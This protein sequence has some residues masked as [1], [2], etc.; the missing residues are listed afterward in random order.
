MN[1]SPSIQVGIISAKSLRVF[2][3]GKYSVEKDRCAC[4]WQD[5]TCSSDRIICHEQEYRELIFTPNTSDSVFTLSDVLIGVSFHWQ[6]S[7]AQTFSG[8]LKIIINSDNLQVINIVPVEDYLVSVISS[9]MSAASSIEFL[10]A[11]AV[12]SRSWALAQIK[13]TASS[14]T[15]KMPHGSVMF[16]VEHD[17]VHRQIRWYNHEDHTLFDVCADDHCQRYHGI[18]RICTP[19]SSEAV[20]ATCGMVL[21]DDFGNICD[22]RFS[23]CCGGIT[24]EYETCWENIHKDYLPSK[25]DTSSPHNNT[26]DLTSED[27]ARRWIMS[28]P[29]SFCNTTDIKVLNQVLNRFDF[30]THDFYRWTVVYE[31]AELSELVKRRSGIDFGLITD[32]IPVRRGKSG[33]ISELRIVGEK[34][35]VII[36]K[37]LEIRRVLSTSHLLSSAFVVDKK[38]DK[39]SSIF[40][41][42]GAGWGHGVGLCQIGAAIM[43]ETGY[44]YKEILMH[45]YPNT[46]ICKMY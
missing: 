15:R 35:S 43:G 22:T 16:G 33:R 20:H 40:V 23:K 25:R 2:F 8:Q 7:E 30:E 45:Y 14:D 1:V 19:L 6:K 13:S 21:C 4:G 31:Q 36:G 9:E 39:S 27:N 42:H 28:S 41:L 12:I 11:H 29:D 32:L 18:T 46:T 5:I 10:K 38:M 3:H 24:E 26:P 17:I 34:R 44:D 37:E